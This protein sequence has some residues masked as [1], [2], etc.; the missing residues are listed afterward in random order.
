M[1]SCYLERQLLLSLAVAW[2]DHIS[3]PRFITQPSLPD[4]F[5]LK[6][7]GM[8]KR[9]IYIYFFMTSFLLRK[10][11]FMQEHLVSDIMSFIHLLHLCKIIYTFNKLLTQIAIK[12]KVPVCNG[13]HIRLLSAHKPIV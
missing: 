9:L 2:T 1:F 7:S 11:I 3:V 4:V 13:S 8:P 10:E 5:P 6:P 12:Q